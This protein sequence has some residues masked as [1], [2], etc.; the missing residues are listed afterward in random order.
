MLTRSGV[1]KRLGKSIATVRRME[2][3]ELFPTRD[4]RGIHRFDPEEVERVAR[5][6]RSPNR[7]P[8]PHRMADLQPLVSDADQSGLEPDPDQLWENWRREQPERAEQLELQRQLSEAR[9]A[10]ERRR[11]EE[12]AEQVLRPVQQEVC[13]FLESLTPREA[14]RLSEDDLDALMAVFER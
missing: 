2:G 4:E 12:L 3:I 7:T 9:E 14:R 5:G 6:E 11:E 10:E 13:E 1:A 8:K